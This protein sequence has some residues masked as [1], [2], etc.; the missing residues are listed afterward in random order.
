LGVSISISPKVKGIENTSLRLLLITF[1]APEL[2]FKAASSE[3]NI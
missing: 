3:K 2:S 1:L